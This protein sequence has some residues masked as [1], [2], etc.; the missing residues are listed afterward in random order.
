VRPD[1]LFVAALL[2]LL[3]DAGA[4]AQELRERAAFGRYQFRV[5]RAAFSPDGKV[6]AAGGGN[7][8]GG[9]LKLWDVAT[10]KEITSL[11]HER[12]SLDALAFSADGKRLASVGGGPVQ[13]WD[14]NTHK[15]VASFHHPHPPVNVLA[16]NRDGTRVAAAG[17]NRVKV[18]EVASGKELAYFRCRVFLGG[19]QSVAFS[20]DLTTLAARNF[21]EIDL[22]DTGTG[23]EKSF[24]SEHW[25]EV[26]CVAWTADEKTLVASS[27]RRGAKVV[28]WKGDVKLWDV[29]SGRERATLPGPFGCILA[30]AVS[31]DG[32]TLALLD[33]AEVHGEADLKV[34]DVATGRQGVVRPPPGCSFLM[35][36]FT[37]EGKLLVSGTLADVLRLWEVAPLKGEGKR[38]PEE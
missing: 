35:P 10:G 25:G 33:L 14:L 2:L 5:D 30:L 18:W 1:G 7:S 38:P 11:P 28:R 3:S 4:P 17:Y 27:A 6:L 9:E 15:E 36:H 23:K 8:N 20:R 16:L 13:V 24:L 26:Q 22:W 19:P 37:P 12:Y 31:P 32:K 21:Q 34:V 29:A